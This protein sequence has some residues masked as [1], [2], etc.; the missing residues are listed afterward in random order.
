MYM[1]YFLLCLTMTFLPTSELKL[2]YTVVVIGFMYI[3][4]LLEMIYKKV[5][6]K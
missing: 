5:V 4:G 2:I 3:I 1:V 6:N